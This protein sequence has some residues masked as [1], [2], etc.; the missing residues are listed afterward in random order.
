KAYRSLGCLHLCL[1]QLISIPHTEALLQGEE[2]TCEMSQYSSQQASEGPCPAS[3]FMATLRLSSGI[4]IALVLRGLH[5]SSQ[6]EEKEHDTT[7][8]PK[9]KIP[10]SKEGTLLT[11]G[12]WVPP[13]TSGLSG[14]VLRKKGLMHV[15]PTL[16][17]LRVSHTPAPEDDKHLQDH[18]MHLVSTCLPPAHHPAACGW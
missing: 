16:P 15:A 4:S 3:W 9:L 14:V 12:D 6:E 7:L 18:D 2:V 1:T 8:H 17:P 13:Q 5:C 11:T 10:M